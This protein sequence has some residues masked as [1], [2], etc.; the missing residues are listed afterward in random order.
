METTRTFASR[1]KLTLIRVFRFVLL[2][3]GATVL[4][5][6]AVLY[7]LDWLA[8]Q[9]GSRQAALE[10][11]H[12]ISAENPASPDTFYPRQVVA[13][14]PLVTDFEVISVDEARGNV[15]DDELV[16]GV[17]IEGEARAY[18]LNMMTDPSREVLN[19][20]LGGRA[21]AATW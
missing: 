12:A 4:S 10:E 8:K 5:A 17:S 9:R 13:R 18:P 2:A 14:P 3:A 21:I 16:L 6:V 11:A 7:G 15:D 20:E 1:A 19:D